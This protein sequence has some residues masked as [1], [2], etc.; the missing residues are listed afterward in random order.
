MRK[1]E[2]PLPCGSPSTGF[3]PLIEL[4]DAW[5]ACSSSRSPSLRTQ[6]HFI[7]FS[8]VEY[9]LEHA[10]K[11]LMALA[12]L[13]EQREVDGAVLPK[14]SSV[15]VQCV[16][17]PVPLLLPKKDVFKNLPSRAATLVAGVPQCQLRMV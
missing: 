11:Y 4:V 5:W 9:A 2:T 12:P 1:W 3:L 7:V 10:L 6:A 16:V 8:F 17:L 15:L 13:V 14:H